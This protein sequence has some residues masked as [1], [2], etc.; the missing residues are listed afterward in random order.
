[1]RH[2][3]I[4]FT[5]LTL[6][7]TTLTLP[8]CAGTRNQPQLADASATAPSAKKRP[9]DAV[10]GRLDDPSYLFGSRPL[11][12]KK[13]VRVKAL[14]Y[15]GC[16]IKSKRTTRGAWGDALTVDVK[17]VAVSPDLLEMGLDRGDVISIEGLPGKYKVLDVMHSRHDKTIDIFYGN[18]A[19][20]ATQWGKRTLNITWQ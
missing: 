19:C 6:L 5:A 17:A 12:P 11:A 9:E 2:V 20:G 1:M 13:S 15:T 3:R 16:S 4:M 18:D 14:A 7:V 8:A 10:I